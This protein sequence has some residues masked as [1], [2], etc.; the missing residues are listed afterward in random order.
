MSLPPLSS[1]E[2]A[3]PEIAPPRSVFEKPSARTAEPLVI[4]AIEI[5]RPRLKKNERSVF[6]DATVARLLRWLNR[7]ERPIAATVALVETPHDATEQHALFLKRWRH[8]VS[9][10]SAS[11]RWNLLA[12]A[13]LAA[14]FTRTPRDHAI[15]IELAPSLLNVLDPSNDIRLAPDTAETTT[16]PNPAVESPLVVPTVEPLPETPEESPQPVVAPQSLPILLDGRDI[17]GR[18]E[19]LA[20]EGGT[21]LTEAAVQRGLEWLK[22]N[23]SP[24]GY[25]GLCGP[26]SGGVQSNDGEDTIAATAMALLAFQGFGVTPRSDHK[27][28]APFA[29]CVARGSEWLVKQQRED[30]LLF[31]ERSPPS[32]RFY[33]HAMAT[34]AVSE[35]ATMTRDDNLRHIAAR[36]IDY[37]LEHQ[38]VAG[39]W[40]YEANAASSASDLSVTGWVVMALKSGEACGV[41][42]PTEAFVRISRFLDSVEECGLYRYESGLSERGVSPAMTAEGIFCRLLIEPLTPD[43]AASMD[44]AFDYLVEP[45]HLVH[46]ASAGR[47][48]YGWYYATQAIHFGSR[49]H[50]AIWNPAMRENLVVLQEQSGIESGSWSSRG[51]QWEGSGGRLYATVFSILMLESYYRHRI[52]K[53]R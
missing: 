50:W 32:H 22:K 5:A 1:F 7:H 13:L 33:T 11:V 42:V 9:P 26:Y 48:V 44:Q 36:A 51:D 20:T 25:W 53:T 35:L 14:L 15:V 28:L 3:L 52:V 21:G 24:R 41:H 23:Q 49:E 30:G 17:G 16:L 4:P 40:K 45:A 18:D 38:S 27:T 47:D 46:T 10:W 39:G 43:R 31:A 34:L 8:L 2:H 29:R 12:I 37:L 6:S 19:L